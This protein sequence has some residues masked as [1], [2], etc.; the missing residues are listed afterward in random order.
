MYL[1][2]KQ[3]I[4]LPHEN[5]REFG[6]TKGEAQN[7]MPAGSIAGMT[8]TSTKNYRLFPLPVRTGTLRVRVST[9]TVRRT[10]T[11]RV[12][13]MMMDQNNQ[14]G[15][16]GLVGTTIPISRHHKRALLIQTTNLIYLTLSGFIQHSVRYF[17]EEAT[18]LFH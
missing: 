6:R 1:K 2:S 11:V 16:P 10:R 18:R 4:F 5:T 13:P 8:D 12:Q 17:Q 7:E 14:D 9:S 3:Q 15:D